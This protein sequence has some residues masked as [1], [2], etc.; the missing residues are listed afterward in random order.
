MDDHELHE[1]EEGRDPRDPGACLSA[2]RVEVGL[3][4]A[5]ATDDN[6]PRDRRRGKVKA[7][8]VDSLA[9]VH[10][11]LRA[12]DDRRDTQHGGERALQ[13]YSGDAE[14]NETVGLV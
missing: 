3:K 4:N 2:R 6:I 11:Q 7:K 10:D 1:D 14:E 9:E 12:V 8:F 13:N 5:I